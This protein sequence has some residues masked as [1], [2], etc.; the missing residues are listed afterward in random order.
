[1]CLRDA[2]FRHSNTCWA[3]DVARKLE[4]SLLS[5]CRVKP[6]RCFL[7]LD[8]LLFILSS[9]QFPS[10][11]RNKYQAHSRSDPILP[12]T[13]K[14]Q[15]DRL[16][17]GS[18]DYA[19]ILLMASTLDA[20][21][22]NGSPDDDDFLVVQLGRHQRRGYPSEAFFSSVQRMSQQRFIYVLFDF[23]PKFIHLSKSKR[24]MRRETVFLTRTYLSLAS[25]QL[26]Y[27]PAAI[28][29]GGFSQV[30]VLGAWDA[31][32]VVVPFHDHRPP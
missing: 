20:P 6:T 32:H 29:Q 18:G 31:W 10:T 14:K 3:C 8:H 7:Q 27:S 16:P 23:W 11:H 5:G 21:F 28:Q 22:A 17:H 25:S 30:Q 4:S 19:R 13:R 9:L 24:T 26:P 15:R 12:L 2:W 1:M